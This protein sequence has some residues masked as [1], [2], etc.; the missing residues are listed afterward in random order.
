MKKEFI[1]IPKIQDFNESSH[2]S[3]LQPNS[4]NLQDEMALDLQQCHKIKKKMLSRV[5]GNDYF[6][7][8]KVL[9]VTKYL[10]SGC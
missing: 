6:F 7:S 4:Y 5:Y 1:S 8:H 3:K 2:L 10:Y 9:Q